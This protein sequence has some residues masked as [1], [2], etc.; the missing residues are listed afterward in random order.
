MN[1]YEIHDLTTHEILAD[2]MFFDDVP[3]LFQA[4][5]EFYSMHEIV[6]CERDEEDILHP[7][8]ASKNFNDRLEFMAQWMMLVEAELCNL[9]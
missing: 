4:Y 3:E 7:I 5:V 9:Y 8:C 6:F 2:N 1:N